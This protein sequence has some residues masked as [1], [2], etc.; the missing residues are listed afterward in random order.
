MSV[1]L[2]AIKMC[3]VQS[4][5]SLIVATCWACRF[6]GQSLSSLLFIVIFKLLLYYLGAEVYVFDPIQVQQLL[7]CLGGYDQAVLECQDQLA[8]SLKLKQ[9]YALYVTLKLIFIPFH[10][11]MIVQH[12]SHNHPPHSDQQ[13]MIDSPHLITIYIFCS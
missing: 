9:V 4:A 10:P 6:N 5:I 3:H 8:D 7:D 12:A 1:H 11:L 2:Y 13:A